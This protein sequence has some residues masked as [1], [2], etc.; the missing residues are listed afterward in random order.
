MSRSQLLSRGLCG[1]LF[2]Q[3]GLAHDC[4]LAGHPSSES[5][6]HLGTEGQLVQVVGLLCGGHEAL[7]LKGFVLEAL[8]AIAEVVD[9]GDSGVAAGQTANRAFGGSQ[10]RASADGGESLGVSVLRDEG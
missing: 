5:A 4:V 7:C 9:I 10:R 3:F 2:V 6:L 1:S 8:Q